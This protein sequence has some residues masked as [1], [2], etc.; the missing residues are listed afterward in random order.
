MGYGSMNR[1]L[2]YGPV[3]WSNYPQ[4]LSAQ[5]YR[6]REEINRAAEHLRSSRAVKLNG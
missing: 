1:R 6:K 2:G 3:R 4:P 5:G